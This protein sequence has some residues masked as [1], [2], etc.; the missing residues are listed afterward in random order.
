M[1]S[2]PR[3]SRKDP[4]TPIGVST[5]IPAQRESP[6]RAVGANLSE[7][8]RAIW[9]CP[10]STGT[11]R[12]AAFALVSRGGTHETPTVAKVAQPTMT[13]M[14][15]AAF[16]LREGTN[17][18]NQL[19]TDRAP[20]LDVDLFPFIHRLCPRGCFRLRAPDGISNIV[21]L[22]DGQ[23]FVVESRRQVHN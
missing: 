22:L 1:R 16:I 11:G 23:W 10:A 7:H 3:M 5:D 6:I 4:S 8:Q 17:N 15:R 9:R 20:P 21:S 13:R 18:A 2:T 19:L 14:R 12:R